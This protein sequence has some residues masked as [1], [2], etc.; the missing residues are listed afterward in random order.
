MS[1]PTSSSDPTPAVPPPPAAPPAPSFTYGSPE[2]PAA[3]AAPPAPVAAPAPAY[4]Q[5]AAPPA[6]AY[7]VPAYAAAPVYGAAPG[8]VR[9]R[10]TW[11]L[12]LTI[13]LLVAGLIGMIIGVAY[14]LVF[15]SPQLLAETLAQ[16]GYGQPTIDAA[17]PGTVIIASHVILYL[18]AVGLSIFLLIKK[19]IAFYVPLAAGVIAAIVFWAMAVQVFA[20]IPGFGQ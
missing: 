7:G 12:V 13:I 11:D 16:Q 18:L 4:G 14:G 20:S 3:P 15:L 2:Q 5:P 17:G 8:G 9:P 1:E 10:R 19:K 6:P